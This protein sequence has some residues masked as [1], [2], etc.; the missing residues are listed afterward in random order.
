MGPFKVEREVRQRLVRRSWNCGKNILKATQSNLALRVSNVED[1]TRHRDD[2]LEER[3]Q[4]EYD[5]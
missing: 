1:A 4:D 2:S 5:P 3:T